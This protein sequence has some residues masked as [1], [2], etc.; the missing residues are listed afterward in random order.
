M[1]NPKEFRDLYKSGKVAE[2]RAGYE[3]LLTHER[4]DEL[5]ELATTIQAKRSALMCVEAEE[6]YALDRSSSRPYAIRLGWT[7]T[8]L[9]SPS[10]S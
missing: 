3:R 7:L 2:G 8:L 6:V 5:R 4:T 10:E 1:G 9:E